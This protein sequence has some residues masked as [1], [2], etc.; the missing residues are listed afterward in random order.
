MNT[1]EYD[2]RGIW[3][4]RTSRAPAPADNDPP[5]GDGEF[6]VTTTMAY[7]LIAITLS[8]LILGVA[9]DVNSFQEPAPSPG[10]PF[11]DAHVHLNDVAAALAILKQQQIPS[12]FAFIGARGTNESIAEAAGL[13]EGRLAAFASVSPERREY[14]A[15][16]VNNDLTLVSDLEQLL[17]AG[18]FRGIGEISVVHFASDG[19]PEADFEP[20]G[21]VMRGIMR[22]AERF[23]LPI[24]IHC[25]ITRLRELSELLRTFPTVRV[26]W[27]HGGYTP[28]VLAARMIGAHPNLTYELSARTWTAHPR[29]PDYTIFRNDTAV[30]PQ[31]LTLIEQNPTRFIVGTDAS[32]RSPQNELRKIARVRLL[33]S[34]LSESTRRLVGVENAQRLI[35][36]PRH[37]PRLMI[38]PRTP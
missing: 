20:A 25:E 27:A 26:I 36:T 8:L 16:W 15:R 17:E 9:P 10:P 19:F 6:R 2:V 22:V 7:R 31:W 24:L 5:L 30:W 21:I 12:A 37:V 34:Q 29:S 14:R 11:V 1:N 23:G 32:Y 33:L 4:I 38:D 13:S 35:A 3:T 18:G 28:L